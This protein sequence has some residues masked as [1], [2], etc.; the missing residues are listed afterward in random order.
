MKR[1]ISHSDHSTNLNFFLLSVKRTLGV[2]VLLCA[3]AL[4]LCPCYTLMEINRF[5]RE[6]GE[7][8]FHLDNIVSFIIIGGTILS[9][10][11][12]V[13]YLFLNFNYLYSRKAS[14]FFH[15]LP[16]KRSR[17]LLSRYFASIVPILFPIFLVY[18]SLLI[19]LALPAVVGNVWILLYGLFYNLLILFL[20]TAFSL[21]FLLAASNT[22]DFLISFFTYHFG[23]IFLQI[24]LGELCNHFLRGFSWGDEFPFYYIHPI[25]YAVAGLTSD[26]ER[27][28]TE[29]GTV[30]SPVPLVITFLLSVVFLA[31]SL[32]LYK[33]RR[34][35][36]S[37]SGHAF[38]FVYSVC[39]LLIGTLSGFLVGALFSNMQYDLPYWIFSAVGAVLGAVAYSAI[40]TR[41]FST[42]RRSVV[43]G[44]ISWAAT[45]ILIFTFSVDIYGFTRHIPKAAEVKTAEISVGQIENVTFRDAE[46]VLALHRKAIAKPA[47]GQ[48]QTLEI[49]YTMKNGSIMNRQYEVNPDECQDELLALYTSEDYRKQFRKSIASF[50]GNEISVWVSESEDGA[51]QGTK[52][53]F[54]SK[55]T[56]AILTEAYFTDLNHATKESLLDGESTQYVYVTGMTKKGDYLTLSFVLESGFQNTR[57]ALQEI[58]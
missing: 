7:S 31:V 8:V 2:T 14:D 32:F 52:E 26:I 18:G 51:K 30:I 44:T 27:G 29:S 45:C 23:V 35:E 3:F 28:V 56:V 38:R 9:S 25:Y 55:E 21:I 57:R 54:V 20:S 43:L 22:V 40:L 13:F 42:V 15:A 11:A 1:Q 50:Y 37:G 53:F 24:M 48:T 47:D 17:M 36:K 19:L 16:I 46:K 34:S 5:L 10:I 58:T 4:L 41:G 49:R 6:S 12:A 33:R 39:T